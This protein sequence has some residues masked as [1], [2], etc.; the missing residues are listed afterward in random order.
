MAFEVPPL[1]H[2]GGQGTTG[3]AITMLNNEVLDDATFL[4]GGFPVRFG[5]RLSSV[6]EVRLREGNRDRVEAKTDISAAGASV[7]AG[8]PM[9]SKGSWIGSVRR[10]YLEL[11]KSS[12]RLTTVPQYGSYQ[13]KAV[14]DIDASNR[15]WAV[16]LGG[17]DSFALDVDESDVDDPSLERV[18]ANGRRFVHGI[19]WQT[20]FGDRGF[21][22]LTA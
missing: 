20:L 1:N 16:G 3:G 14:F 22:R 6:L 5:N 10:S 17:Y 11:L 15:V 13:A 2:F 8:G 19:G 4:T 12:L 7:V 18:R 9:G 21:G